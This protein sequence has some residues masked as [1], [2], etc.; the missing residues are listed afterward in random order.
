MLSIFSAGL[1]LPI[2]ATLIFFG[3]QHY[4]REFV[5]VTFSQNIGY[6]SSWTTGSH[7]ISIQ[8]SNL[9]LKGFILAVLI[10]LLYLKR[11]R[12]SPK[13]IFFI[14]WFGF[15]L[16]A[17]SLSG[18]PYAHYLIQTLPPLSLLIGEIVSSRK[19][20]PTPSLS[21]TVT[22]IGLLIL[23]NLTQKNFWTY[24]VFPY[25]Q[26]FLEFIL[27][28]KD[29]EAYFSY[30]DASTPTIYQVASFL[31]S[32]TDPNDRVFIWADKPQIFFL[33]GRLPLGRFIVAYHIISQD[34]FN[35]TILK[36]QKGQPK[37]IILDARKT[38]L[39]TGLESFIDSR[40]SQSK[41]FGDL[42]IFR[43]VYRK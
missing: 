33:A 30:F 11:S 29:K 26:N 5:Q 41:Q 20:F 16:A 6:L 2:L 36:L 12:F 23:I 21:L 24:R 14:L 15:S 7:Q 43:L 35:E 32:S 37:I 31:T 4:L 18:R 40:Y 8:N 9:V 42:K 27:G 17:A 38:G 19:I 34:K 28:K 13:N 3:H 1:T 22:L 39:F 25:Y 10:I